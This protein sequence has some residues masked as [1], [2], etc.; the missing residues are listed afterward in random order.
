MSSNHVAILPAPAILKD[1]V[2]CL[3][4]AEHSSEEAVA[5]KVSPNGLPGI[6]F[7]HNNG[8]SALEQI[9]TH[10][11]RKVFPPPLFLYGPGIEPSVMH[12]QRGSSTTVQVIFKPHALKTL[13][14]LDASHL[15]NGSADLHEFSAR[16]LD[17]QLI[18]ARNQ[19]ERV[20]L[21]TCFLAARLKQERTRDALVEESLSLIH[22]NSAALHVKDLLACLHISERQF[23][24]RFIRTVG[25]SPQVF[26]RV[27][28]FNEAIRLIKTGQFARLTDVA[29]ALNFSDQSHFIRDL[30]AFSGMTPKGLSQKVDDFYHDQAGYSYT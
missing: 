27:K 26:I 2:E 1:Y 12:Y 14:G 23:E 17:Y 11:G 21:L 6:V 30:K 4:I 18:E 3:R 22:Q 16:D 28:R 10:S 29:C 7:H 5:I 9:V 8:Y 19:Q 13:L 25:L 24:R 20:H 15:A